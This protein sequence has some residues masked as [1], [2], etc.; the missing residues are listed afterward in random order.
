MKKLIRSGSMSALAICVLFCAQGVVNSQVLYGTLTGNVT[1]PAGSAVPGV[2]IE[3]TNLGTNIKHETNTDERGIYRFTDLQPGLYQVSVSANSFSPF[4][5]TNVQVQ[6]NDVRRVDVKLQLASTTNSVTVSADAVVLQTD[7][8][9]LHSEVSQ[10]EV[11]ELPYNGTEGKNFQS[12]L[13][14]QPGTA[15]TAG[16]GEANSA[17]G[18]PQRAITVFQNGVSSQANNTRLDGALDAYPW[19]PVNIGYVPSP[20]AIQTVPSARTLTTPSR[21][22]RGARLSTFPLRRELINCMAPCSSATRTRTSTP[23][24]TISATL[25]AWRR[26]S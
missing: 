6:A 2:H 23:S 13:L 8:G 5:E 7:K 16:T 1:D 10:M 19:L 14:L 17:A 18:N 12:L 3:A 11:A 4:S 24:I 9:D 25:A 21:A 26:T 15:T 20:E 22:R